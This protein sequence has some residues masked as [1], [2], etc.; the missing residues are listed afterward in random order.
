KAIMRALNNLNRK[1]T[2]QFSIYSLRNHFKKLAKIA[3]VCCALFCL[4][5]CKSKTKKENNLQSKSESHFEISNKEKDA[6]FLCR[7][8]EIHLEEIRLADLVKTKS[9]TAEVKQL[10]LML[11][12]EHSST[13]SS[14]I[15]LAAGHNIELPSKAS[16]DASNT[17][18]Q[19]SSMSSADFD[20]AYCDEMISIHN[21]AITLFS[22]AKD[23]T[24]DAEIKAWSTGTL[25]RLEKH[26][27][28]AQLTRQK[29]S[30][31]V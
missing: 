19:L 14:L 20:I 4:N 8:A 11:M 5:A 15:K 31:T 30:K 16:D 12:R 17:F 25:F 28:A 29:I 22:R 23:E 21:E 7:A 9:N 1:E 18:N 26:L 2:L 6:A 27:K 10:A 3:C 13:L 24:S